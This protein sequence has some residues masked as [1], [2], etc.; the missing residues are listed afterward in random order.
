MLYVTGK[1]AHFGNKP[2]ETSLQSAH[3][4][5]SRPAPSRYNKLASD[6]EPSVPKTDGAWG[7][8]GVNIYDQLH[9]VRDEL[10]DRGARPETL[11]VLD[12]L[13]MQAEPERD[14]PLTIT[15]SMMVR[16]LLRQR[17]VLN[18]EDVRMDILALAGDLDEQRP[19]RRDEDVPDA[20][21]DSDKKPQHLHSYYKK[22]REKQ[23]GS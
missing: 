17:D 21:V 16:H 13:I 8:S 1:R 4:C 6:E 22:Q 3:F 12:R 10:E 20:T 2:S 23:H 11:A 5:L 18:N 15:Q 9:E 19:A 7:C 14:N